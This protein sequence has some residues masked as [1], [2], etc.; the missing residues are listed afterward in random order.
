MELSQLQVL[1]P[2]GRKQSIILPEKRY[3]GLG[4]L[5]NGPGGQKMT[6]EEKIICKNFLNDAD[7]THSCNEYKLLMALLEQEPREITLEDVKEYCKPRCL[8]IITN[9][10]L[11]E[12]THP[13]V[14][15]LE[16]ESR[17]IPASERLPKNRGFYLVSTTDCITIM[18]FINGW[19]SQNIGLCNGYV[20]AWMPLPK[21]CKAESEDKE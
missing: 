3:Q 21:P 5:S 16:Q 20:T 2:E 1:L 19:I 17:W 13:K 18:E 10:L 12:L 14:K 8:T 11:Y 6:K 15:A 9:E 4:A 7:K